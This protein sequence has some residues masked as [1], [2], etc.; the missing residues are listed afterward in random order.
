MRQPYTIKELDYLADRVAEKV[1]DR[2]KM[3]DEALSTAEVASML[4]VT[5]QAVTAMV[6]DGRLRGYRKGRRYFFSKNEVL[7]NVLKY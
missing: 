2:M 7:K 5:T 3:S 1:L 6:R 4:G